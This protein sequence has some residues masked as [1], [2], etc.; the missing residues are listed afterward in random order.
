MTDQ[1]LLDDVI[2]LI[3]NGGSPSLADM[4]KVGMAMPFNP[5]PYGNPEMVSKML[6]SKVDNG[7]NITSMVVN[8]G[9]PS[10]IATHDKFG[11][12]KLQSHRV[13]SSDSF[14][15]IYMLTLLGYMIKQE[16]G[17]V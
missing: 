5:N 13:D 3:A 1:D 7:W 4:V 11:V 14:N 10:L 17:W 9:V 15:S 8:R 16:K 12:V 2:Y 6:K